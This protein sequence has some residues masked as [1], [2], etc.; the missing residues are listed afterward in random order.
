MP[1]T[2]PSVGRHAYL[3]IPVKLW[4]LLQHI[5]VGLVRSSLSQN[6]SSAVGG[7]LVAFTLFLMIF[8]TVFLHFQKT[9]YASDTLNFQ[10]RLLTS[11]GSVAPDG[12]YN[13]E[14]KLYDQESGGTELWTET[15]LTTDSSDLQVTVRSGYLSVYLGD[16]TGFPGSIDW[17]DQLYLTMNIGGTSGTPAWDGEMTP[18]IRLTSVPF[19]FQA[20][21]ANVATELED[22]QGSNT[23]SLR[24]GALTNDRNILL[25]NSSGTVALLQTAQ[26]FSGAITFSASGTGLTVTNSAIIGGSLTVDGDTLRVNSS[27]S[28]V[29]IGT[30]SP[31]ARLTVTGGADEVQLRVG[32]NGVQTSDIF[33]ITD[34]TNNVLAGFNSLGQLFLRDSGFRATLET[35]T[36]TDDH[37]YV[38]PDVGGTFC[39]TSGN[40]SGVGGQVGGTGT[41][42]RIAMFTAVSDIAD[43][44]LSQDADS[45]IIDAGRN[46]AVNNNTL[47]V[48]G[49]TGRVGIGTTSPEYLLDVQDG[50]GTVA[51]FS[52]RVIGGEAVNSDEFVTLAQLESAV[53]AT[54]AYVLGGNAFGE[55]AVLGTT[56]NYGLQFVT[57]GQARL[58]IANSGEITAANALS[59]DG[60]LTVTSGGANITGNVAITGGLT[61]TDASTFESAVTITDGGLDVTGPVIL[62]G[63]TE[64]TDANTFTVGTGATTLGGTLSVDGIATF[65]NE[66]IIAAEQSIRLVGGDT[67]SRPASPEEGTLY[68][69]TQTNR[70]LVYA[71]GKWQAD[72]SIAT[73]IVAPEDA[74]QA[75]KDSADF[76]V[77]DSADDAQD[78][79]NAAIATLP[80]SGGTVYL[81]EGTYLISG[82][83]ELPDNT[84][85]AGAGTATVIKVRDSHDASF[86]ALEN[87]DATGGNN[88]ITLRDFALD[89]NRSEQAAGEMNGIFL[90]NVGS[91]TGGDG[92]N[93]ITITNV[94]VNNFSHRGLTAV[95][96]RNSTITGSTFRNNDDTG[97]ALGGSLVGH[98]NIVDNLVQGNR[99][100]GIHVEGGGFNN[101]SN[102]M[103]QGNRRTGIRVDAPGNLV[104]DNTIKD[105]GLTS[106]SLYINSDGNTVTGNRVLNGSAIGIGV[107]GDN[108]LISGNTVAENALRGIEVNGDSNT[109]TA[110]T[111]RGNGEAAISIISSSNGT[112]ITSNR[113]SNINTEP[114]IDIVSGAENTY[115][116]NN[117]YSGSADPFI[118]DA[119]STTIYANQIG[120]NGAIINRTAD[121]EAMFQLQASNGDVLFNADT[122]NMRIGIGT[123]APEYALD[124]VTADAISAR[125]SGRVIGAAAVN[126]NEFVTLAQLESATGV[127]G[128]AFLQ[129]GNA[130][131]EAA[132]LGTTDAYGLNLIT[133]GTTRLAISEVGNITLA[134]DVLYVDAVNE[135]VQIGSSDSIDARLSVIGGADQTQLLVRAHA[136]QTS[137]LVLLQ[138]STGGELARL[139]ATDSSLYL[140]FEAGGST[141]SGDNNIGIGA[142]ALGAVSTGAANTTLGS[143]ALASVS[144]GSNNTAVGY[145]A[146]NL[147]T[148]SNNIL[149]GY[150]AG[151]NIEDG[152]NNIIIGYSLGASSPN[153]SNE[154]RIGGILQGNLDTLEL[155]FNGDVTVTGGLTVQDGLVVTA[156]G[157]DVTGDSTIDGTLDVTGEATFDDGVTITDG[158]ID[159][160]GDST[161]TGNLGLDGNFQIF[162]TGTFTSGTGAVTLQ[163]DTEITGANTFTVGTGAT[164]LGGSLQV[165]GQTTFNDTVTVN[166]GTGIVASFS[167]R[168]A[169]QDAVE[170]DEFTTLAQL[171]SAVGAVNAFLQGG[172]AFDEAAVL[173]TTDNEDLQF[174]TNNEVRLTVTAGGDITIAN[175]LAVGGD[176]TVTGVATFEDGLTVTAGG[177]DV[178]GDSAITGNLDIT[179]DIT[180]TGDAVFAA[181]TDSTTT[182]QIQNATGAALFNADT[183]NMRIGIGTDAPEYALDVVTADAISARFSG[184]VIGAAAVNANEFVTLAQLE[185]ATGVVGSAFLQ[186]GNA[187]DEAAVLGTTDAYGLNLITDGT[188]RLAISEVGNITLAD[189]VLYVDAVNERV[190]IGSSDSIDARLSVIGGAD[191]TQLLVRAHAT[192]TSPLVLLQDST[193]GEL[194][195]LNATDSSL[196]L[197]FEAGGSTASGDNNIGIGASA[198]GAVSTGAANTTLGSGALA[199]VSI[200]SNNTAVGYNAGNLLTGS[201]NILLG[202]EA[203]SNIE[204]GSNNIIIGYSLGASSPNVSNELR[205]GG[206]LQGNLDTLELTFNGD[207]TVTGGLTVQD[208]LV[209]TAGG[210]DVTGDST[211]DGTLDVT[212]EATFDD[213]VTITDGGID[214]T[215]DSTITGNLG[216]DGNFQIFGTGTFTSGTGAV[217]LQGD[218]EITGA[219][220]FTVGTGATTLGGSLQVDGQT[221]FNDTVTVN[222]GT[223]IVASFSGR[224]AGQD[225]VE[226]DEFTTLAQLQ[227]AVGAVNA[228]L[229][230]GNAFD[231][232]A[233]LGTTDNE[234]LQFITNNEVRLTVTAGG[235][236]TIANA[237]AVG[238]DLTVTGVAT[239]EDGLTVTA[240]GADITGDVSITGE[241][242]V[243]GQTTFEDAITVNAGTGIVASFSGRV[244]GADA[245]EQDEFTTLAQLQS[246]VGAVNAFLQG[247]NAFDE[248]AVLGTTDNYSLQFITNNEARLAIANDGDV[249][250]ANALSVGGQLTVVSGGADITGDVLITGELTVTGVTTFTDIIFVDAGTGIVASFSGRVSGADA[251]EQ[252]EFVTLGQVSS[253][254]ANVF[255]QQGNNFGELAVLGTTDD[256]GLQF[257]T[258]NEVRLSI[259]H[260]GSLS[261]VQIG[262]GSDTSGSST[263]LT[264]DRSAGPPVADD[265]AYLGSMYYD[266]TI[267]RI[268]CYE[269]GGWGSCG[270]PPDNIVNLDPEYA[271]AVLNGSGIGTMTADFCANESGVLSVNS[272]LCEEGEALNFYRWASPQATQQTY[273]IYI[274]YQLPSTFD[275]F[276][277]DETV[278]L[279][280]RRDNSNAEVSYE[281]FRN[282]DGQITQCGT[283]TVVT[284]VDNVW[285]TV[286]INGDEATDCGFTAAS[287]NGYVIFKINMKASNN[288]NA[289]SS[290]LTFTTTGR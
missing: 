274:T 155:T 44:F 150:E 253:A 97:I 200:G 265:D 146:G 43:S 72:R 2:I 156:G 219:N 90:E 35:A 26:T 162:G 143:G 13:V 75:A 118:V 19:A 194:A 94:S 24:F 190:Q 93:G 230:G 23:G 191:Q 166:A 116:S 20:D 61:V 233:V 217:T 171:Q 30:T 41:A 267:G 228:F 187:F 105:N 12:V 213:G 10:A 29:G 37:S 102:N 188:T 243:T 160:T 92:L 218:T 108:N 199:S 141:A 275:G 220:T 123:D 269:A 136:T 195:R 212:G 66:V 120:N 201:N 122:Q 158:G 110:N 7:I 159:V 251:V 107:E 5:V 59:V 76:V 279:T 134:D 79:L 138:D 87:A 27:T 214:V 268:Q 203:G 255:T 56:D 283:E 285:Q 31:D 185:S 137:P 125:F 17:N 231:E 82:S 128:S 223:G 261:S 256:Y 80:S 207:V 249:A 58:T 241:L 140:G 157:I 67:A 16:K 127:V 71:N 124:V 163:G 257:I 229:Q 290:T 42:G 101:I 74:T 139:N 38:L 21:R 147:L 33:Q 264:L 121:S 48:D 57:N 273:G 242:S 222:A 11:S 180:A 175:A 259:N 266:T 104:A 280:A 186:G 272:S 109:V 117:T 236:I 25:P 252:D 278:Q 196:Y 244:S 145:N 167:G 45:I 181:E 205:I 173:G 88:N 262:D 65:N 100:M 106:R 226:Q 288:A 144:I 9:I 234:D 197:G 119:S 133:D 172:N 221:T 276:A 204:D 232:A 202:Y 77:P 4:Q 184:R 6:K 103:V 14:F 68:F 73:V 98:N 247:G 182:F 28:R 149:L 215:G 64:I 47:F 51:R 245:V 178:I 227:S 148:G 3:R 277:S 189:D 183:Q 32:A 8:G 270:S 129:G 168:V 164:T 235:D 113:I 95:N 83:I 271:G 282:Q 250:I 289:Y 208:G 84:T 36:L 18:R 142:S 239:F 63:N 254:T 192:Q 55:L 40:C 216:L 22:R 111:V 78:T 89:G 112:L 263:L 91:D 85:L 170:Q 126:A 284:T 99:E 86:N 49:D 161:I 238:G 258:N 60:Q 54:G 50:T 177:I 174:I 237:L 211:I 131:D 165:D 206:I 169:G 286:G 154:L 287:A 132:V 70:L 152:S 179:G 115:L 176:L 248:A 130:F 193:G 81:L 210:I 260:D 96:L 209:V 153:V 240:G 69:D 39:L 62:Q 34:S 114:A 135:R 246:A 46:L 281:M 224:V 53:G 198:L 52:G 225:A 1:K 151:S 15:R